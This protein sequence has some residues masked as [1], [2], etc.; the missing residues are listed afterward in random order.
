MT[1][2]AEYVS[3]RH[4]LRFPDAARSAGPEGHFPVS[5]ASLTLA[6]TVNNQGHTLFDH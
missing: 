5:S 2:S 6:Q 4:S 1:T 3:L